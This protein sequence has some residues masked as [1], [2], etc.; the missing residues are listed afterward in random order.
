M[1]NIPLPF[2]FNLILNLPIDIIC[3]WL[4]FNR[5]GQFSLTSQ[6]I[7]FIPGINRKDIYSPIVDSIPVFELAQLFHEHKICTHFYFVHC[8]M[9][10]RDEFRCII[11]QGTINTP[12]DVFHL[13]SQK[14]TRP[15]ARKF[16]IRMKRKNRPSVCAT[17]I[18]PE[19]FA[20]LTQKGHYDWTLL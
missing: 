13:A 19:F 14:M 17:D 3:Q 18:N 9:K 5:L 1:S 4:A 8:I 20:F 10:Y 12:C 7:I 11:L 2:E 16:K 15:V 6:R